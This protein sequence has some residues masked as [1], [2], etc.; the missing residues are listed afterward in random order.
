MSNVKGR[1]ANWLPGRIVLGTSRGSGVSPQPCPPRN[2]TLELKESGSESTTDLQSLT[3]TKCKDWCVELECYPIT[4]QW[5][6]SGMLKCDM[7]SALIFSSPTWEA[8]TGS[9]NQW[10]LPF[11]KHLVGDRLCLKHHLYIISLGPQNN[12]VRWV[13]LFIISTN[14]LKFLCSIAGTWSVPW[15]SCPRWA[16]HYLIHQAVRWWIRH[17]S[18]SRNG[19]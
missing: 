7:L 5:D 16:E 17:S 9:T 12:S 11:I 1:L 3:L 18:S 13:L 6:V 2:L 10:W 14:F 15:P 19:M 8:T 4:F